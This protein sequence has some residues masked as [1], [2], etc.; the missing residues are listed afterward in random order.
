MTA[1]T[2]CSCNA[3]VM[4]VCARG[5]TH[6][7][8]TVSVPDRVVHPFV[9]AMRNPNHGRGRVGESLRDKLAARTS[10]RSRVELTAAERLMLIDEAET[11]FDVSKD[12]AS[13]CNDA[14]ADREAARRSLRKLGVEPW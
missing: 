6:H 2:R 7:P 5:C 1:C 9:E 11:L 14:K 8:I 3:E 13:F 4:C 12:D 10:P